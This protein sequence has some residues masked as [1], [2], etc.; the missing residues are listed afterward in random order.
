M[1]TKE[2]LIT[3]I[4]EITEPIIEKL[5]FKP[6]DE[7]HRSWI[8]TKIELELNLLKYANVIFGH[9]VICDESN[10]TPDIIKSGK[11]AID[12]YV[13]CTA[14]INSEFINFRFEVECDNK[15]ENE[16]CCT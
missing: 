13:Q 3:K 2:E 12:I 5:I 10:N 9:N 7:I 14:A 6:N 16:K 8:K 11:F 15:K 1:I 4:K